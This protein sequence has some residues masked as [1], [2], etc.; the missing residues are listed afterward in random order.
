MISVSLRP[1][2][3]L[4]TGAAK[5]AQ[6]CSG[7]FSYQ[8]LFDQGPFIDVLSSRHKCVLAQNGLYATN[9]GAIFGPWF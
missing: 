7:Q 4:A 8:N 6:N 9:A 5:A 2:L 1:S 3:V